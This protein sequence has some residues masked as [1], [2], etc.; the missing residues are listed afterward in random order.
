MK[1]DLNPVTFANLIKETFSLVILKQTVWLIPSML[2]AGFYFTMY[3][4]EVR[5]YY[6]S[7][8]LLLYYVL[9]RGEILLYFYFAFT[10]LCTV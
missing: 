2:A 10:L 5:F 8:L 4:V 7:T 3:C 6:T 1:E 9:C